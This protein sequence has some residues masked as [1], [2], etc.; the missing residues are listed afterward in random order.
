VRILVGGVAQPTPFLDI[1]GVVENPS[2]GEGGFLSLVFAPD[3]A[4]SGVFYVYY[5]G[6]SGT[7]PV[8]LRSVVSRFTVSGDPLTATDV[9]EGTEER[10]FELDQPFT[11]HNGG[12]V[13]IRDG[14]LYLGL[15]D[16]G[17]GGDP[18]EAAQDDGNL[19]GKLVRLDL[20]TPDP[21]TADWEVVAKGL[22]N[23]FRF[24]FDRATGD[25]YIGDVGQIE[26]EEIDV[27]AA[28]EIDAVPQGQPA[29]LNFGW[30]VMEGTLCYE[31][32]DP[33]EPACNDPSLIDPVHVYAH[34]GEES[35]AVIGGAVYRGS[36][37][38]SMR[39]DYFFS[40]GSKPAF[41]FRMR[42]TETGGLEEIESI[43][44]LPVDVG[45]LLQI[46]AI[47]EDAAG[48]LH[49]VSRLGSIYRLVP[50]PHDAAGAAVAIVALACAARRRDSRPAPG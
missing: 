39:G 18:L 49:L 40:D 30:D 15:G 47:C 22:R 8:N 31:A 13:A 19:L 26:Q 45:G 10:I 14:H 21:D 42:W 24:S 43:G 1:T 4:T 36:A 9:D 33:G 6:F 5:T 20:A 41:L 27:V 2:P 28:A 23:P 29:P 34:P 37:S 12:T 44:D 17:D 46:T 11:N 25:L 35:A 32:P 38:R 7:S 48:E 50:E 16:G 3:Y